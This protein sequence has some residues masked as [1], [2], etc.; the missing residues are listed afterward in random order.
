RDLRIKK[1]AIANDTYAILKQNDEVFITDILTR[2]TRKSYKLKDCVDIEGGFVV[3]GLSRDG[4]VIFEEKESEGIDFRRTYWGY[5]GVAVAACEGHTAVL[6]E[7]GTV[8]CDDEHNFYPE[9]PQYAKQVEKLR[10]VKQI[11]LTF[12]HFYYLTKNGKLMVEFEAGD[13]NENYNNLC[14]NDVDLFNKAGKIIQIAAFGCYFSGITS[15]ALYS[16][17]NVRASYDGKEINEVKEW[18]DVKKICC[19]D[20]GFIFG[21]TKERK[22]LLPQIF[23]YRDIENNPVAEI[24]DCVL[25]IAANF[26][27]FIALTANGK[28][29]Y[30]HEAIN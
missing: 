24:N 29:I 22:A 15:A 10:D 25:D 9:V 11:V 4:K 21:L 17:G 18:R 2:K 26:T 8:L 7:D 23:P 5:K 28:I 20:H 16:D 1:I 19:A 30:L 13:T 12:N 14:Q 27:N 6:Q 3:V